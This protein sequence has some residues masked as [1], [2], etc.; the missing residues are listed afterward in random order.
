MRKRLALPMNSLFH[1]FNVLL[2]DMGGRVQR[3]RGRVQAAVHPQMK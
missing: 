3:E 2:G 1:G